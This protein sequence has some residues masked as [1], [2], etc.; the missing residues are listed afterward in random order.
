VRKALF[1]LK[2][3]GVKV[4]TH[5]HYCVRTVVSRAGWLSDRGRTAFAVLLLGNNTGKL[6]VVI[7]PPT[8]YPVPD[9]CR[10]RHLGFSTRF[11][12]LSVVGVGGGGGYSDTSGRITAL[13]QE[14]LENSI[15]CV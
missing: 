5:I 1:F 4:S 7:L 11:Q 8:R 10:L 2:W 6:A 3:S 13:F 12:A 15:T 9:S 14:R